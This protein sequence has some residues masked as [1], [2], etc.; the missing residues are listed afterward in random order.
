MS[1]FF[2][3][4]LLCRLQ[5][6]AVLQGLSQALCRRNYAGS[7][8][9]SSRS[10]ALPWQ[11]LSHPR[12]LALL[13]FPLAARCFLPNIS[14]GCSPPRWGTLSWEQSSVSCLAT[15][16]FPQRHLFPPGSQIC[17]GWKEPGSSVEALPCH[18]TR[19]AWVGTVPAAL[20]RPW[21]EL[22]RI[23]GAN[24]SN[25]GSVT[26]SLFSLCPCEV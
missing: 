19:G 15:R 1:S 9:D 10:S 21:R 18:N 13:L 11:L 3:P 24:M 20:H 26:W 14:L 5:E 22:S 23:S 2:G 4:F 16:C 12:R 17:L 7:G 6:N 8:E 25:L